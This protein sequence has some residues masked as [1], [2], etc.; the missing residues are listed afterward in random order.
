VD[1]WQALNLALRLLEELVKTEIARGAGF[2]C[3]SDDEA[4]TVGMLFS[5]GDANA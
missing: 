3:P 5:R 1:S 2:I 4:I